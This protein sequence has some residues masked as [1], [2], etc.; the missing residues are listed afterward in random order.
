M[1]LDHAVVEEFGGSFALDLVAFVA[2]S[3]AEADRG[4]GVFDLEAG[5]QGAVSRLF[6]DVAL[7]MPSEPL[8]IPERQRDAVAE[9]VEEVVLAIAALSPMRKLSTWS[10]R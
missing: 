9:G 5:F 6:F 10:T 1:R 8:A 2:S 4:L 3:R 7:T